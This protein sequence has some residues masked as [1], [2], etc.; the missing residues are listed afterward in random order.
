MTALPYGGPAHRKPMIKLI[1]EGE[2][3]AEIDVDLII[4]DDEW[5]PYLSLDDAN[6]LDDVRLALRQ[7]NMTTATRLGRVYK[8]IPVAA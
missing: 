8:L 5:A 1:R 7:G 2:F 3:V 4:T 6:K